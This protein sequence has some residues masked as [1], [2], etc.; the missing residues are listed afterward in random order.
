MISL[1][2]DNWALFL[3]YINLFTG[4]SLHN[5]RC[6]ISDIIAFEVAGH[7]FK[8]KNF[9]TLLLVMNCIHFWSSPTRSPELCMWAGAT[10][11][12]APVL[13]PSTWKSQ[14]I[15]SYGQ[16]KNWISNITYGLV[17]LW[18][19]RSLLLRVQIGR[20]TPK[21]HTIRSIVFHCADSIVSVIL[22]VG[23]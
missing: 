6:S 17:D 20:A 13:I 12:L 18:D 8:K 11:P 15:F 14:R 16:G 2:L 23:R 22:S 9:V 10:W 7:L 4:V 1:I 19:R 3:D 21:H 5:K